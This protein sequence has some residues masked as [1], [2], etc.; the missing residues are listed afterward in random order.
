MKKDVNN[1]INDFIG[2]DNNEI[3]DIQEQN[4]VKRV[5]LKERDGLIERLDRV[6]LDKNG[7]QLLSE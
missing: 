3:L 2:Q 4:K 6:Y 1:V 7:K 5:I